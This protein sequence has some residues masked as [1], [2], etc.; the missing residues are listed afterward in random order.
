MET[1]LFVPPYGENDPGKLKST[2]SLIEKKGYSVKLIEIDWRATVDVWV[3]QLKAASIVLDSKKKIYAGFSFG[4]ITCLVA[5]ASCNPAQLWLMSLSPYFAEDV[6]EHS[7]E[8]A[9]YVRE[10]RLEHV[11]SLR[12]GPLASKITCPTTLFVGADESEGS[13]GRTTE[14]HRAIPGSRLIVVPGT[15]HD[16]YTPNYQRALAQEL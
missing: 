9:A 4:A 14:A 3:H 10:N 8:R 15:K 12:F 7:V 1:V 6:P 5:A 2:L 16:L 11:T 13:R